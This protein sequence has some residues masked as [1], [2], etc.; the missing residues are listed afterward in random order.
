M[1][2]VIVESP[3]KAKTI[4]RF[5]G[6]D[7]KV[8]A[9]YGHIRDLPGSADEVPKSIKSKPWARLAVDIEHNF[10][11]YY[12]VSK[13]SKKRVSEIK[14]MLGDAEVL[15]LATDED[16]EGESISWHLVETLKPKM[17]V[18]RIVFHEI[19]KTAIDEAV[20]NPREVNQQLVRAQESR[21]ILDRL[22]GFSLSPVLWR[23]V[24]SRLSAGRV[25]SVAVRLVV[26][27]EE[28]RRAFRRAAYWDIEA[29]LAARGKSF[30]AVLIEWNGQRVAE[31]K[32]FD[33]ATGRLK[34]ERVVWLR[35]A[36][37]AR[38]SEQLGERVP[39]RVTRVEQKEA[40]QRPQPP[41]ITSTLQQAASAALG[42]A[43]SRTMAIAQ[44]LYEGV[45][46][47]GGDREGLITYMRT[48]SVT[49]AEKALHEAGRVIRDLFGEEYY[50][51]PRRYTTKSKMAQEA[52]EAI[53]PT[54]IDRKPEDVAHYL[55]G[56]Q[57]RLY[58]LVW[59]RTVASQMRD[60]ELLKTT[61]DFV[62]DCDGG[63]AVL[64][65]AGSVVTFPGFLRVTNG[66]SRD[67]ELPEIR[68][69]DLAGPGQPVT[70][71]EIAPARHETQPPARFTE[72]L[73][74]RELEKEGI[75][76][77]STYAP[78]IST[79]QQRGYVMKLPK[80]GTLAPTYL[81]IAVTHLLRSHFAEYVDLKF[82]ARMEDVLDEIAEGR[83]D[84]IGFLAGFYRGEGGYGHGLERQI[85]HEMPRIEFPAI[86]VGND[87]VTGDP[88]CVRLGKT[89]PYVQRGEGGNG[90]TATIPES[91]F[92]EDLTPERAR[93]LIETKTQV[94]D[95]LGRDPATGLEV[96]LR[97]GPY[98]LYVQLGEGGRGKEK[99]KR[100]SL[101]KET[102][103]ESVSLDLAL[104]FL[105]LPRELGAHPE[106][107]ETV[108]AGIGRFGPYVKCGKEFRSLAPEDDVHTVT[109]ERALALLA[110][111]K[112][113]RSASKRLVREMG[114]HPE[115]GATVALYEGRFGPY[116]TDGKTNATVPKG[117][118]LDSLTLADAI[119]LLAAP[120]SSR[121]AKRVLRSLG[122]HPES[123]A[124]VDLLDG[125]YGPYVTDGKKNA[126]IPKSMDP[127]A[128][129][130][131][132]AVELL[133]N[134]PARKKRPFRRHT[135][136]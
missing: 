41:F 64:R 104:K 96:H 25:Q 83:L 126:T 32:D 124:T 12:V 103:P 125:R 115:S 135:R 63:P 78:I 113:R 65:A 87:P 31:G 129:T 61:V 3:A 27:R 73:L 121:G 59:N 16:R 51:G 24:G 101:P 111:P 114:A 60:A 75:G 13:D 57:L 118:A 50:H 52:H 94:S 68:E 100:A 53:R 30:K 132:T 85:E 44:Q 116:V 2:L 56:D 109:L 70:I 34:T 9:S 6:R 97:Q 123:G 133:A 91:L 49:L 48:D 81:G 92:F 106:N 33:P 11:P 39:W 77:P 89:A 72:A 7:Y 82:T 37:A 74:I 54:H 14:A 46:L 1:K 99:P 88:I 26:E 93:E 69:G 43:P 62:A 4:S 35:E 58:R 17:P 127:E 105:A 102:A 21:R 20:E 67:A 80:G 136:G 19:T 66:D 15:V 110:A 134:A 84:W 107:G 38:L 22:F 18:Q 130:L 71:D 76:R 119:A 120:R 55:D 29:T 90:N 117:T 95:V 28:A 45:D 36:D 98:G 8:V 108:S 86:P 112:A 40:R 79:I 122:A 131:D 47:G 5:L 23:K 128:V 42:M 10:T